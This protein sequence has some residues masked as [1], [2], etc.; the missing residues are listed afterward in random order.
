[1][2]GAQFAVATTLAVFSAFW[3]GPE[4]RRFNGYGMSALEIVLGVVVVVA[5]YVGISIFST[6]DV[7]A[8]SLWAIVVTVIST[9]IYAIMWLSSGWSMESSESAAP[10]LWYLGANLFLF[11]VGL[12]SFVLSSVRKP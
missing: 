12:A 10:L 5:A 4:I 1:M 9:P 8:A 11:S 7:R 3:F 2:R 6:F